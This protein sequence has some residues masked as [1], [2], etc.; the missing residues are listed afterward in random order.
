M[1]RLEKIANGVY[2]SKAMER[3]SISPLQLEIC[4]YYIPFVFER[5][6][7]FGDIGA[8]IIE[9]SQQEGQFVAISFDYIKEQ[10]A[11][12]YREKEKKKEAKP[13]RL[14]FLQRLKGNPN[15]ETVSVI[16]E[17]AVG[18]IKRSG[19]TRVIGKTVADMRRKGY[20]KFH[21][22]EDKK[23]ILEPT[24]KLI[25]HIFLRQRLQRSRA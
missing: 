2:A 7:T 15:E 17:D 9:R 14:S 4:R 10:L 21:L 24:P 11:Q 5:K 19:N 3:S 18:E 16:L 6:P 23:Y 20:L 8:R 12:E 1:A 25:N 13:G 22:D